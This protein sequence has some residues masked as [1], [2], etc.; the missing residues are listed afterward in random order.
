MT[1]VPNSRCLKPPSLH[2]RPPGH[3]DPRGHLEYPLRRPELARLVRIHLWHGLYIPLKSFRG[4]AQPTV[5]HSRTIAVSASR[6]EGALPDCVYR[7]G[8]IATSQVTTA[9]TALLP[10]DSAFRQTRQ[11]GNVW[12]SVRSHLDQTIVKRP[13][14]HAHSILKA[15]PFRDKP[16]HDDKG[17]K[18]VQAVISSERRDPT[19]RRASS[20][21]A[22]ITGSLKGTWK[23]VKTFGGGQPSRLDVGL[24]LPFLRSMRR[25]RSET[26]WPRPPPLP[27]VD[28]LH[29]AIDQAARPKMA[30]GSV[31]QG[32]AGQVVHTG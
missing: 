15:F 32:R 18:R 31:R 7:T 27:A 25:R 17:N 13:Q 30:G 2:N 21:A 14:L 26:M 16:P 8:S 20:T 23:T 19:R 28:D 4:P 24:S 22:L 1:D 12:T 9:H 6:V 11:H 3:S 10:F 29:G 5:F